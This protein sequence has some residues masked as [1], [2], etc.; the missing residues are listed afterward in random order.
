MRCPVCTDAEL[1]EADRDGILV[2]TCPRCRGVW[3]ERRSLER[4]LARASLPRPDAPPNAALEDRRTV[5]DDSSSRYYR[6]GA[7]NQAP[8]RRS[9]LADLFD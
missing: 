8:R 5:A 7:P 2:D 4:L 6:R 1:T 9:W 3:L